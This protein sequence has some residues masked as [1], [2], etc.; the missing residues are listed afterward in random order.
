M[1]IVAVC[2]PSV[3]TLYRRKRQSSHYTDGSTVVGSRLAGVTVDTTAVPWLL[4]Q[5]I[6]HTGSGKMAKVS[7]IQRLNTTGGLAPSAD[8]CSAAN[9]GALVNIDYTADYYF[10]QPIPSRQPQP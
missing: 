9:L 3:R 2:I 8:S 5:A 7:F 1:A 10:Y 6:A 4:L